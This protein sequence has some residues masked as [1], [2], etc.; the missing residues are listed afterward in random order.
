M[1]QLGKDPW[2]EIQDR[3]PIQKKLKGKITNIADYGVL[4]KLKRVSRVWSMFLRWIGR[5]KMSIHQK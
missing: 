5:I 3:Y 4:L 1:K 2:H